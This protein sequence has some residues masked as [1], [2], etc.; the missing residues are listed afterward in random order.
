MQ[1]C[2]WPSWSHCHSLSLASVKSRL[3]LPFWYQLSWVVPDKWPL[4]GCVCVCVCVR[5]CVCVIITVCIVRR[6][7]IERPSVR[8]S[9][10]P[11]I[12]PRCAASSLLSAVR[13]GD[14]QWRRTRGFRRFSEPGAPECGHTCTVHTGL[15]IAGDVIW[16]QQASKPLAAGGL[17]WGSLHRSPSPVAALLKAPPPLPALRASSFSPW[18]RSNWGPPSYCWTRALRALLHHWRYR[19]T[20]SSTALSSKCEQCHVVSW[21]R[22][23][24]TDSF[25]CVP[26]VFACCR[27][28]C[29]KT[30]FVICIFCVHSVA[31]NAT[32]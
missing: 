7:T 13:A 25:Y 30:V 15:S 18:G 10:C 14:I 32:Y 21:R 22:K 3:V 8:P 12:R 24:I 28:I 9:V 1:T 6:E 26:I 20:S 2:I 23:L 27:S 29:T 4:N 16:T 5:A 19:S 31:F 17:H 11:I